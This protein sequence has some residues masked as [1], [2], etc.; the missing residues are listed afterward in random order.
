MPY[1]WLG[2]MFGYY[3]DCP[4]SDA[5]AKGSDNYSAFYDNGYST[6][7]WSFSGDAYPELKNVAK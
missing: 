5:Q 7:I 2:W 4:I 6:D 3:Y 1:E